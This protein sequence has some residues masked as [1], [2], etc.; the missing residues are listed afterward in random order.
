MRSSAW[1]GIC[2]ASA[3]AALA[4]SSSSENNAGTGV[5]GSGAAP[6][7]SGGSSS[8]PGNGGTPAAGGGL[9]P[10]AGSAAGG[11]P[12]AGSAGASP[13]G[14]SGNVAGGG[15]GSGGIDPGD[16]PPVRPLS[17][18]AAKE[19]HVHNIGGRPFAVDNRAPK[20]MGKLIIEL[21]VDS[22]GIYEF[23]LKRGFHVYGADIEH[24]EI[25]LD[26]GR[27]HNGDCRMETFDGMDESPDIDVS[28]AN[29]VVGKLTAGLQQ[30]QAEFPEEDW[31]YFLTAEGT[32]RWSDV[33]VTG[34][35]HGAQSAARWAR[36]VRM[37]RAVSRS[38][39]RDNA[40]GDGKLHSGEDFDPQLPPYDP[41][42]APEDISAWLDEV[43]QTPLDRFFGFVGNMDGQYGDILFS[44]EYMKYSGTPVNISTVAA[45]YGG[46]HRFYANDGHSSF[47]D[48]KYWP[49]LAIAWGV[50]PENME[51][52]A[53]L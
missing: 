25:T 27:E 24:C 2:S 16:S 46:S 14:G 28:P 17:I 31:G 23:G 10:N 45:P 41:N 15:S 18:T 47:D 50:P 30:L 3:L 36:A 51:F 37:Y 19:E 44:M 11:S 12:T 21:G 4:C 42:C 9:I 43:S 20:M 33:G 22:G 13:G 35:S 52:A 5:S 8:M 53:G 26:Q 48:Q 32:V 7:T 6:V 49:A 39:P 29:S 40:C 1:I 34:V 38:G